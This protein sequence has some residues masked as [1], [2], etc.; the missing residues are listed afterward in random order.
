MH[1]DNQR[2][3]CANWVKPGTFRR[4]NE[5][6]GLNVSGLKLQ[7]TEHEQ[8][9]NDSIVA[10]D[11]QVYEAYEISADGSRQSSV[12]MEFDTDGEAKAL[13]RSY[14]AL[15]AASVKLYRVPAV[16]MTGTSSLDLWPNEIKFVADIEQPPEP[17][18]EQLR[19][20]LSAELHA[21]FTAPK[22]AEFLADAASGNPHMWIPNHG[23]E[24]F[25]EVC[26]LCG[27]F[28][29]AHHERPDPPEAALPCPEPWPD[30]SLTDEE[31]AALEAEAEKEE[32]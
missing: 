11:K 22:P 6:S 13:A 9:A 27:V 28:S 1:Q 5:I 19:A 15:W 14:A 2:L 3:K 31:L 17:E 23:P 16:N 25:D 29:G 26:G 24:P 21:T 30:D 8:S 10:S 12:V 20:K 4:A 32:P 7:I 18:A